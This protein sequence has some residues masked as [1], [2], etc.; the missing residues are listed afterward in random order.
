MKNKTFLQ[1]VKCALTGFRKAFATE[2]NFKYYIAIFLIFFVLNITFKST[3]IEFCILFALTA[4]VFSAEFANTALEQICDIISPEHNERIK[5]IK[6][7]AA[8]VVLAF[9]IGFFITQALILLPK[10][11]L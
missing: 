5:N 2:K 11:N 1:S 4:G 7:I 3:A 6:D 8:S 10:L 9:G